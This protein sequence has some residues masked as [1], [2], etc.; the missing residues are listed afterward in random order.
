MTQSPQPNLDPRLSGGFPAE[1][2][3]SLELWCQNTRT[4]IELDNFLRDGKTT[5]EVAVVR[6]YDDAVGVT[7]KVL[8]HCPP[9]EG[10]VSL[11]ARK[12]KDAETANEKFTHAHLAR[13]D[14]FITDGHGGIFLLME[15][16]G[17]GARNYRPLT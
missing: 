12:Y 7:R 6:V 8:K 9:P 10:G 2:L 15:W 14:N 4:K 11:D 17:G 3:E 16:R 1:A 13:L 5:A